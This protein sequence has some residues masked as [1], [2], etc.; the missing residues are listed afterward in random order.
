MFFQ[1]LTFA[2]KT[3]DVCPA[4]DAET[5]LAV[6]VRHPSRDGL[7]LHTFNCDRCG[8]IKTRTVSVPSYQVASVLVA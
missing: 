7:E 3:R 5:T 6:I 2:G 4:C 8:P 1:D